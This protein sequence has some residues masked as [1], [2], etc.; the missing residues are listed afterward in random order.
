MRPRRHHNPRRLPK[1]PRY[2]TGFNAPLHNRFTLPLVCHDYTTAHT[3]ME[4]YSPLHTPEG[5]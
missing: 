4:S 3:A 5:G 2:S 1:E